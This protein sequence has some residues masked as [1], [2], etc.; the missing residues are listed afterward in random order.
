MHVGL[1]RARLALL[2]RG[3]CARTALTRSTESVRFPKSRVPV[4][5]F[6]RFGVILILTHQKH[7]ISHTQTRVPVSAEGCDRK[8]RVPF[9]TVFPLRNWSPTALLGVTDVRGLASSLSG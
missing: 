2:G 7:P 4:A 9:A 6:N 5:R 1:P 8:P 3:G